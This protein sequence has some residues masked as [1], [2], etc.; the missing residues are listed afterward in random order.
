MLALARRCHPETLRQARW[1]KAKIKESAP[2]I[3]AGR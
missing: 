3:M 2:Q 1:A